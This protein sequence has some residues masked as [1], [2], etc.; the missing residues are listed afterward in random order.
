MATRMKR[1]NNSDS[2]DVEN[3]E[4]D[5]VVE[6][7]KKKSFSQSD[8]ILVHSVTAGGLYITCPSGNYYEFNKYGVENEMEYRDLVA[9]IRKRSSHIFDPSIIIDDEDFLSDFKQVQQFYASLFT[10]GDLRDILELP[11]PQM[12]SAI[13]NLPDEAKHTIRTL[14]ATDVA[15]GKIDSVKKI[16]AL[17]EIFGSDFELLSQLFGR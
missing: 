17:T 8:Y 14:A 2:V 3:N 9:L 16:K 6:T 10:N 15:N 13:N 5:E 12:V 4:V 1:V 11:I 7:K